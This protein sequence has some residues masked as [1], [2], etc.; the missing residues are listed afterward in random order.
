MSRTLFAIVLIALAVAFISPD[1]S[2]QVTRGGIAQATI[3][4]RPV[5][6]PTD[7][8]HNEHALSREI[9]QLLL[10]R[11]YA[12]AAVLPPEQRAEALADITRA[13]ASYHFPEAR[14]W[15]EELFRAGAA[16]GPPR[17]TFAQN[18]SSDQPLARFPFSLLPREGKTRT[19]HHGLRPE[20]RD[21]ASHRDL[22]N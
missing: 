8:A 20:L 13:A 11:A 17:Q 6:S 1:I 18:D 16:L 9:T 5:N 2:G 21:R 14:P 19:G 15:A 3:R 4:L 7:A 12:D 22:R 10:Q